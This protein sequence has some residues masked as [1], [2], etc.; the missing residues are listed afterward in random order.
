M[1]VSIIIPVHNAEKY[2]GRAIRSVLDQTFDKNR[3]E[4]IVVNDASTDNT[5]KILDYYSNRIKVINLKKKK[6]LAYARNEG[7]RL[8]SGRY[9]VC[10]D[11]DDYMYN[12]LIYIESSFLNL[13]PQWDAVSCDYV[14]VN[15]QEK[16]YCMWNNVQS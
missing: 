14:I 1:E 9:T 6:G 13:N 7:I 10:L 3:F 4:V 8:S 5:S 11:A 15:E 12:D 16:T 2:I